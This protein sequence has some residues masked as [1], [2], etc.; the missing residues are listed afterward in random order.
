M[1]NFYIQ[2]QGEFTYSGVISP[3]ECFFKYTRLSNILFAHS[4][5][6][7]NLHLPPRNKF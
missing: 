1:Q 6:K 2:N 3:A 7:K 4:E 5:Q